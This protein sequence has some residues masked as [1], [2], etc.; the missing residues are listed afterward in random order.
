MPERLTKAER[1]E[2]IGE[3]LARGVGRLLVLEGVADTAATTS[4]MSAQDAEL[5]DFLTTV[6]GASPAEIRAK[7]EVPK[8]TLYRRLKDLEH[9]GLIRRKGASRDV[10]YEVAA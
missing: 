5:L 2:R 7:F 9:R 10:V 3:I 4:A 8:T 6:S 1:F